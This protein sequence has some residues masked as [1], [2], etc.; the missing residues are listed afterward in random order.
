MKI[1]ATLHGGIA[2]YFEF[3]IQKFRLR[4]LDALVKISPICS[5]NFQVID[6]KSSQKLLEAKIFSVRLAVKA[7]LAV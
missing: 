3:T 6:L 1:E 4:F 7:V 2:I 5:C